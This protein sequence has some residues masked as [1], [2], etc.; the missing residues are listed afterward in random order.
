MANLLDICLAQ[1][2]DD[3][4]KRLKSWIEFELS[5]REWNRKEKEKENE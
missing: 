4:L 5:R 1:L 3:E 2:S